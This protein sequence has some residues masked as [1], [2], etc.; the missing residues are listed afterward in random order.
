[1]KDLFFYLGFMLKSRKM[2][3]INTKKEIKMKIDE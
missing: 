1:M 3:N 2:L